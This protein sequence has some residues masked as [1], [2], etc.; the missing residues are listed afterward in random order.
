MTGGSPCGGA[1]LALSAVAVIALVAGCVVAPVT[2]DKPKFVTGHPLPPYESFRECVRLSR[3]D[4]LEYSFEASEPVDFDI[5]Y[6][7]GNVVVAPIVRDKSHADAGVFVA[8][9]VRDYCL[10]WEAGPAGAL[11]D[12][13]LR[14]RPAAR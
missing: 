6:D 3:D 2:A 4:R 12:Y 11:V 14:L 10:V 9:I 8:R 5:R 1:K 13:R 7:E